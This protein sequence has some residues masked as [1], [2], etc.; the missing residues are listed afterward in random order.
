MNLKYG[1]ITIIHNWED[2]W[3]INMRKW[4]N[5]ETRAS[6]NS[7]IIILFDDET[8]YGKNDLQESNFIIFKRLNDILPNYFERSSKDNNSKTVTFKKK[9]PIENS[10]VKKLNFK[11]I[12]KYS[13][14]FKKNKG[15]ASDY[16][17]IYYC[18]S[19]TTEVFSILR[20]PSNED[21]PRFLLAYDSDQ[22]DKKEIFY[23]VNCIF[24]DK[25]TIIL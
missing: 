24:K 1:E 9:K 21:K 4:F 14:K 12:F 13:D 19:D 7:D 8:I 16:N 22:F 5:Y 11:E 20:I 15:I 2:N 3:I 6:E 17:C 10:Y 23:L 25:H 18:N